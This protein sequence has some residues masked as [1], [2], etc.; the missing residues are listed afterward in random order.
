MVKRMSRGFQEGVKSCGEGVKSSE[1]G[2]SGLVVKSCEE[3]VK[4]MSRV[5][6]E[7]QEL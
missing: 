4:N 2:V 5:V 3:D 1:Q 6:R 7:C